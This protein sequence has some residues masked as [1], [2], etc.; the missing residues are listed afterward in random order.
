MITIIFTHGNKV[1]TMNYINDNNL[2][3]EINSKILNYETS[4]DFIKSI[5]ATSISLLSHDKI[6]GDNKKNV[7]AASAELFDI[8]F[9][10]NQKFVRYARNQFIE[11][12]NTLECTNGICGNIT[13]RFIFKEND[14]ITLAYI[15]ASAMM[16]KK[17]I[18][19]KTI[20]SV[21]IEVF[22]FKN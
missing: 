21:E 20:R 3:T 18:F 4:N 8:F 17:F 19:K 16:K 13:G 11:R 22:K 9:D 2:I 1:E 15:T 14:I 7:A 12:T 5:D 10:M 6:S